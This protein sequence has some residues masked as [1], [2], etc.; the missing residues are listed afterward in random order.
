MKKS[1]VIIGLVASILSAEDLMWKP[2]ETVE[3]Q[4]QHPERFTYGFDPD[5][6]CVKSTPYY[7]ALLGKKFSNESEL[8]KDIVPFLK[9][10]G[11]Y[12]ATQ[13][14]GV[15]GYRM[16]FTN[17]QGVYFNFFETERACEQSAKDL[18][19]R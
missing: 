13:Y 10:N 7:G 3:Q 8:A 6:K 18:G 12:L 1:L 15:S 16:A 5:F 11:F 19:K 9:R 17:G 4:I 2:Y 14:S